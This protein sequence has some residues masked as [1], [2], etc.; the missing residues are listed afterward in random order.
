MKPCG[1]AIWHLAVAAYVYRQALEN[2]EGRE[3]NRS[4]REL[5]MIRDSEKARWLQLL[6][7]DF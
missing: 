2:G 4:C 1:I 7:P 3:G 5:E 6:A